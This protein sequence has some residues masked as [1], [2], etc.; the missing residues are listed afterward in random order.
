M[1]IGGA[2]RSSSGN[3]DRLKYKKKQ[4]CKNWSF[5]IHF[6]ASNLTWMMQYT[7]LLESKIKLVVSPEHIHGTMAI[8]AISTNAMFR[9]TGW[10]KG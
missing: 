5:D 4:E 3:L 2:N 9:N 10:R 7:H 8:N 6:C 1:P